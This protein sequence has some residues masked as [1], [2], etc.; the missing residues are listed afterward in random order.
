MVLHVVELLLKVAVQRLLLRLQLRNARL[1]LGQQRVLVRELRGRPLLL[2]LSVA[3]LLQGRGLRNVRRAPDAVHR[4]RQPNHARLRGRDLGRSGRALCGQRSQRLVEPRSR[5]LSAH[6]QRAQLLL[7]LRDP[8]GLLLSQGAL[9]GRKLPHL[10]ELLLVEQLGAAV[11]P[12]GLVQHPLVV[13]LLS[14]GQRAAHHLAQRT[15]RR[16]RVRGRARPPRPRRGRLRARLRRTRL[17]RHVPLALHF[18]LPHAQHRAHVLGPGHREAQLLQGR[19]RRAQLV[20]VATHLL[21]PHV[22]VRDPVGVGALL[23]LHLGPLLVEARARLAH[24]LC[25]EVQ[26]HDL[27]AGAVQLGLVEQQR[28]N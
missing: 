12:L 22:Q 26:L 21:Q 13:V 19:V 11:H 23:L 8:L 14:R 2:L 6:A 27:A 15:L 10:L 1:V 3:Q 28:V 16:V 5:L 9:L 24:L 7:Q 20:Q 4:G 25:E 18:V 17:L